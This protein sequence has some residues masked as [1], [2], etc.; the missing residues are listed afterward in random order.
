MSFLSIVDS[1]AAIASLPYSI[2]RLFDAARLSKNHCEDERFMCPFRLLIFSG[3]ERYE[4][5]D[6]LEGSI[7]PA[8]DRDSATMGSAA[9]MTGV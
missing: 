8:Q 9:V 5:S 2:N 3:S 4:K 6:S 1:I 7:S